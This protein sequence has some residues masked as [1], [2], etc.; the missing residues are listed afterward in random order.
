MLCLVVGE[1]R[2]GGAVFAGVV[3]VAD[4]RGGISERAERVELCPNVAAS[5]KRHVE[6]KTKGDPALSVD[7]GA[8][9]HVLKLLVTM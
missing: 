8:I 7:A 3:A 2:A 1:R 5:N 9:H 6:L 4:A